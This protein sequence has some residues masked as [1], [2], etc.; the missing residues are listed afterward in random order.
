VGAGLG[1]HAVDDREVEPPLD[2]LDLVPADRGQ[3]GVE[4]QGLQGGPLGR[5]IVQVRGAGIAQ[6][7]A[8]DQERLAVDQQL[9]GVALPGQARNLLGGGGHGQ[10]AGGQRQ[11]AKGRDKGSHRRSDDLM[12]IVRSMVKIDRPDLTAFGSGLFTR[13]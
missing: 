12:R 13:F 6:F 8:Q 1:D 11:G 3:H 4:V 2:R 9:G 5:Q 10:Q 7:A